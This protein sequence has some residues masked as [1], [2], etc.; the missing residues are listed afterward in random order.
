MLALQH[1]L[2]QGALLRPVG[3]LPQLGHQLVDDGI[4]EA[5][6]VLRGLRVHVL[7]RLLVEAGGIARLEPPRHPVPLAVRVA[8]EERRVV[9]LADLD[10][11]VEVALQI[12]LD[13]LDLGG[14]L[15]EVLVVEQGRFES[16]RVA[17][18]REEL[19]G[20]RRLVLPPGAELRRR[21]HLVLEVEVGNAPAE[22]AVPAVQRVDL[23]LTID[24]HGDGPPYSHIVEGRLVLREGKAEHRLHGL[25][26]LHRGRRRGLQDGGGVGEAGHEV[27]VALPGAE[28]REA[29][30]RVRRGEDVILV[31]VGAARVEVV[32]VADEH[33]ADLP[34]VLLEDEGAGAHDPLLQVAILF[35]D[36]TREDDRHRLR[37]IL[38]EHRV[39]HLE[40]HAHGVLVGGLD[41][42]DLLEGEG[43][44]PFLGVRL[45]AELDVLRHE[46]PPVQRRHVVPLD[47]LAEL[48]CP[49]AEVGATL[50]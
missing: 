18:F 13:E 39:R 33:H 19:L 41:P 32:G 21:G 8:A 16:V 36:L 30:R 48:E 2:G 42:L 20:L 1:L 29:R 14:H 37:E 46:L 24:S 28:G 5:P 9:E 31:E 25:V 43:L 50:P 22:D 38:R 26:F 12:L 45:E 40:V 44:H 3:R 27:D 34:G 23:L 47:A 35:E 6:V 10:L 17:G 7:V 15:R 11:D 4:G 49:D